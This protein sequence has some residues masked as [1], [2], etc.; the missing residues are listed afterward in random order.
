MLMAVIAVLGVLV[1]GWTLIGELRREEIKV[2]ASLHRSTLRERCF[3]VAVVVVGSPILLAWVFWEWPPTTAGETL[4]GAIESVV[5]VI[6]TVY[7]LWPIGDA[8]RLDRGLSWKLEHVEAATARIQELVRQ[9]KA[10]TAAAVVARFA[11]SSELGS[12]EGK[13]KNS[14]DYLIDWCIHQPSF[15]EALAR[16]HREKLKDFFA[17]HDL[18]TP[19][20]GSRLIASTYIGESRVLL[21]ETA[22]CLEIDDFTGEPLIP[23][24]CRIL[25][26]LT[27]APAVAERFGLCSTIA[28]CLQRYLME[29]SVGLASIDE[30]AI[31]I[32][33]VANVD[34]PSPV[35]GAVHLHQ[36]MLLKAMWHDCEWECWVNSLVRLAGEVE[37]FL[38]IDSPSTWNGVPK[39]YNMYLVQILHALAF[40]MF[41]SETPAED[42]GR[43]ADGLIAR[44][45]DK[46]I[47]CACAEAYASVLATLVNSQK[48]SKQEKR[49]CAESAA[50]T[51][52]QLLRD[53]MELQSKRLTQVL[54]NR[55]KRSGRPVVLQAAESHARQKFAPPHADAMLR[56]LEKAWMPKMS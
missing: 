52:Q 56:E 27:G 37:A 30:E 50:S 51:V 42:S 26:S 4:A 55:V 25:R 48:M 49:E 2:L 28:G 17:K 43:K 29:R 21:S 3:V 35:L 13:E 31:P 19:A 11:P 6:V 53:D 15:L 12:I 39:R 47:S 46:G 16:E 54:V 9:G 8:M 32:T 36:I 40:V 22:Q 33:A 10:S 38:P 7:A 24:D 44:E 41:W 14:Y 1:A 23:E 34:L 20:Q 5:L 45:T 18:L